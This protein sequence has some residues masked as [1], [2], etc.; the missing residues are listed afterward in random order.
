MM[1]QALLTRRVVAGLAMVVANWVKLKAEK[2]E[3]KPG[4]VEGGR[5][6]AVA[7]EEGGRGW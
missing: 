2:V 5:W 6:R 3:L 7:S 1:A 4:R